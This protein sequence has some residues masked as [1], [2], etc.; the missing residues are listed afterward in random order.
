MQ[1]IFFPF[2]QLFCSALSKTPKNSGFVL[3]FCLYV[4][5]VHPNKL[6]WSIT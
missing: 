6:K 1:A 4:Q 3:N 2:T 5:Q